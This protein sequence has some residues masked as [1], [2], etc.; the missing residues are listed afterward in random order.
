MKPQTKGLK[1]GSA[2]AAEA[3]SRQELRVYGQ[4][5]LV[6]P[7]HWPKSKRFTG[8]KLEAAIR[9]YNAM[10]DAVAHMRMGETEARKAEARLERGKRRG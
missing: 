6:H 7:R 8:A 2:A 3:A 9:D 4:R 10:V 5:G 1:R